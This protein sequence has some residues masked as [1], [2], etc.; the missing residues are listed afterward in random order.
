MS[1][2]ICLKPW[3]ARLTTTTTPTPTPTSIMCVETRGLQTSCPC[4]QHCVGK[5][6]AVSQHPANFIFSPDPTV[7]EHQT[8]APSCVR[9]RLWAGWLCTPAV[10]QAPCRW[11]RYRMIPVPFI[12]SIASLSVI[13]HCPPSGAL[14]P[15]LFAG[16]YLPRTSA[17]KT[18]PSRRVRIQ[19]DHH[20]TLLS[21][22]AQR[23]A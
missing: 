5:M 23:Q 17:T 12:S 14:C 4:V 21:A 9:G 15:A 6:Q 13:S 20:R 10:L 19:K 3:S 7:P 8:T 18:C 11:H 16:N 1:G 22:H 2:A